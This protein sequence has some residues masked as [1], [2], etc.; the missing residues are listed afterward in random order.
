M[1][2]TPE[3]IANLQVQISENCSEKEKQI[4]QLYWELKGLEFVN[5]AKWIKE[6]FTISQ[7][8]L[9]KLIASFSILSFFIYCESCKLYEDHQI[10]NKVKFKETV[11]AVLTNN[12]KLLFKCS[13]CAKKDQEKLNLKKVNQQNKITQNAENAIETKNWTNLSNFEKGILCNCFKMN[14]S[15][16]KKHYRSKLGQDQIIV[17]FKALEKIEYQNLLRLDRD[18]NKNEIIDLHYLKRLSDYKNEISLK[19]IISKSSFEMNHETN[20]LKFKLTIN[21]NQHHPDSPLYAGTIT[22]KEKIIIEPGIEYIFGLW[23]RANDNLYLT[24]IPIENLD[25]LPLQ[26]RISGKPIGLQRDIVDFLKESGKN[27]NK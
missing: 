20:E 8:E 26:K 23:K 24:M 10:N 18:L 6:N 9:N 15:D 12:A 19:E 14:F 27:F 5:T 3:K 13:S 22:F 7:T 4:I 16:L 17:F 21:K 25:R 11:K 2:N 1:E